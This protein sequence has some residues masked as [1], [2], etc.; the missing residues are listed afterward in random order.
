MRI[1]LQYRKWIVVELDKP[2]CYL[3]GNYPR[4]ATY[5]S[6]NVYKDLDFFK[7]RTNMITRLVW[8]DSLVWYPSYYHPVN[9]EQKDF[10]ENVLQILKILRVLNE[11]GT[12]NSKYEEYKE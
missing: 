4:T 8:R 9:I 7:D 1:V 10:P 12:V 5:V 3:A 2:F 11:D 6:F